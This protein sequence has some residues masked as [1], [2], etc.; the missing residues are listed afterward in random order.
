MKVSLPQIHV[1][2]QIVL[3][4]N[5]MR[6]FKLY[7]KTTLLA[8]L[9]TVLMFAATLGFIS[10]RIAALVQEDEK[11]LARLQAEE[12]AERIEN[13][14]D[15]R[16]ISLLSQA[17]NRIAASESD[18]NTVR[19]WQK[20][21]DGSFSELAASDNSKAARA[22]P[23]DVQSLLLQKQP[24]EIER[25]NAANRKTLFRSFAPLADKN[26]NLF[27]AV[28]IAQTLD[29][30]WSIAAGYAQSEAGF[31]LATILLIM[32]ATYLLFHYVVYRPLKLLLD[33]MTQAETGNLTVRA[34][35][36]AN[37]E[38]GELATKFNRMV[39][40]LNEMTKEREAYQDTLRERVRGATEELQS[41]NEQLSDANRELWRVSRRLTEVE[42]LAAAGQTAAQ[43]AHE[44]GTPLNLISGHVQLL[45]LKMKDESDA[46]LEII[47]RQIER[48][49][50]IVRTTLD[51][52]RL[53]KGARDSVNVN[54]V[55][56]RTFDATAPL[57]DERRVTLKI[58]LSKNLPEISGN[59]D[60]LQ[61]IFINLINNALDAMPE[62]G[63]LFV[64]TAL[65]SCASGKK[66]VTIDF[67]DTGAGMTDE[68]RGR[69]F[70]VLYTTKGA[71][72]TG[73]GLVVVK[74]I[75]Q[76]H[77]G[78]IEVESAAGK[79]TRFTLRFPTNP[80]P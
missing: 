53:S 23:P 1:Q 68:V 27:G 51:R 57:F 52:T 31:A 20:N 70:D 75:V 61:Q 56:R 10:V 48:I 63:E 43:F 18:L 74:Q 6:P 65:E 67:T 12:F 14:P 15:A 29:S 26:G 47:S 50:R 39:A 35:V 11:D 19:V 79:G 36:F 64:E 5:G 49:E 21:A 60:H 44:V 34:A 33:A 76:E 69:I 16:D 73:L 78:E 54:E 59:A 37:D 77:D 13:L 7:F 30:P 4:I 40:A 25:E 8:S 46:R 24:T 32:F 58:D 17:A 9:I 28:E 3:K 66:C 41:K 72:G 80:S 2:R 22:I 62:S 71:R 45:R 55:L 38:L 42:R